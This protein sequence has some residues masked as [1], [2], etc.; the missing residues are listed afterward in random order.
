MGKTENTAQLKVANEQ[1]IASK[2]SLLRPRTRRDTVFIETLGEWI[3]LRSM[4]FHTRE[5][6]KAESR[7]ETGYGLDEEKFTA[8]T[9]IACVEEPELTIKDIA[10]LKQQ[11]IS[12][13]DELSNEVTK[14]NMPGGDA[15]E[16]KDNSRR[17]PT[18][19]SDSS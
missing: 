2:E 3:K 9:I 10:A 17:T 19:D 16:G 6:I 15:E 18:F 7:D 13:I 5:K 8:L 1:R 12:V 11:D 14:I 4:A